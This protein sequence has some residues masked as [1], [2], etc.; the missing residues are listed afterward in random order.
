SQ[1]PAQAQAPEPQ[2]QA[3]QLHRYAL[4]G[5]PPRFGGRPAVHSDYLDAARTFSIS[6]CVCFT[7]ASPISRVYL[8]VTGLSCWRILATDSGETSLTAIPRARRSARVLVSS[9]P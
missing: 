8:S 7:K 9:S 3:A 6:A 5:P 4:T 2:R 1:G